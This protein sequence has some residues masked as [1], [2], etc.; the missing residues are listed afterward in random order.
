MQ[1][2]GMKTPKNEKNE[3]MVGIDDYMVRIK[4]R[5]KERN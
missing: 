1:P 5:E 4:E 2:N 3:R